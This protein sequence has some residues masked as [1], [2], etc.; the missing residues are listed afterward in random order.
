MG[1]RGR[2]P[3]YPD[4][5]NLSVRVDVTMTERIDKLADNLGINRSDC[6]RAMLEYAIDAA[7]HGVIEM[8]ATYVEKQVAVIPR[9]RR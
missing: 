6:L 2:P 7:E 8:S 4:Q 1:K 9:R 5:M 3:M